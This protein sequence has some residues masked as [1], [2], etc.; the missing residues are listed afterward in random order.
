MNTL[1]FADASRGCAFEE[2]ASAVRGAIKAPGLTAA[3]VRDG[4][5]LVCAVGF[6]D[7]ARGAAMTPQHRMPGGS[8][9]KSIFAATAAL[10][11]KSGAIALDQPVSTWL[12]ARDWFRRIANAD[13]LTLRLLL[14]HASGLPDHMGTPAL[15]QALAA[16]FDAEGPDAWLTPEQALRFIL[17]APALH[18]PGAGFAYSDTNYV[19]AGLAI[20]A[21]TGETLY[22]LA[23]RLVL[24]PLDLRAT[25]PAIARRALNLATGHIFGDAG[26]RPFVGEGGGLRY[27]PRIEWAG[28]GFITAATDLARFGWAYASGRL[29]GVAPVAALNRFSWTQGHVGGYGLGLFAAR[30]SLGE[31]YGH[32]GYFP[33]FQSQFA[34]FP[35]HDLCVAYQANASQGFGGY[36]AVTE[37]RT[38]SAATPP[39]RDAPLSL[40]DDLCVMLARALVLREDAP[41]LHDEGRIGPVGEQR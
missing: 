26:A 3:A 33:G 15:A 4:R 27:S 32:G 35:R 12:G 5:V 29:G 14:S 22:D 2:A 28:G 9:G 16:L 13:A 40:Q 34:Y 38:A 30:T 37:A 10:L 24:A 17:D 21:A 1:S 41:G 39:A 11:A 19:L 7:E 6:D 23:M 25:E 18:A 20:E 31:S 8:T 36:A